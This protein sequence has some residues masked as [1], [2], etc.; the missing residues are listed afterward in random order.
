MRSAISEFCFIDILQLFCAHN[1]HYM[2]G[3]TKI[4]S[5]QMRTCVINTLNKRRSQKLVVC[6]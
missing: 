3:G 1:T 2:T 4:S 6:I 5:G